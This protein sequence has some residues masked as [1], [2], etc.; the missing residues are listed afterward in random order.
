MSETVDLAPDHIQLRH[1]F[2]QIQPLF[3]V[4]TGPTKFINQL[5]ELLDLPEDV[6][7][8]KYK[9]T[10]VKPAN[11][12]VTN[13]SFYPFNRKNT[14]EGYRK[15]IYEDLDLPGLPLEA[16]KADRQRFID[17]VLPMNQELSVLALGNLLK[18]LHE[19]RQKSNYH[20]RSSFFHRVAS[21]SG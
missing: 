11:A 14:Q 15:K 3:L 9:V 21:S 4:A 20:Q 16:S 8:N 13:I 6:D 12:N 1:L 5:V 2:R 7:L 17:S 18:Y 19:L 10:K